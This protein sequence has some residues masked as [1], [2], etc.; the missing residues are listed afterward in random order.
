M[1][2]IITFED[3]VRRAREKH[4][5]K[6]LYDEKS[7]TGM[8]HTVS[9]YCKSCGVWFTQK[10]YSHVDGHGHRDCSF[11][12]S[13]VA[14]RMTKDVFKDRVKEYEKYYVI[15]IEDF[16]GYNK[17]INVRCAVCGKL[18]SNTPKNILRG[19]GHHCPV[20]YKKESWDESSIV[21]LFHQIHGDKYTYPSFAYKN[22]R[23]RITIKCNTCGHKFPVSLNSHKNGHGCKK[24]HHRNLAD[25][26]RKSLEKFI[27]DAKSIHGDLYDYSLVDY[28]G[29]KRY[30]KIICKRCGCTFPQK[31]EVH[32]GNKA[33][34]PNCNHG[35][36]KTDKTSYLY[37]LKTNDET[38]IKV[39]IT[40]NTFKRLERLHRDTPFDFHKVKIYKFTKG[41]CIVDLE[42]DIHNLIAD[43]NAGLRGFDGATEWFWY[44]QDVVDLIDRRVVEILE[45]RLYH[46]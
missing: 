33:G 1:P 16:K 19:N 12:S 14:S 34:C 35:S 8:K 32:L 44:S 43:H 4:H 10:A 29:S 37:I 15:N 11:E 9:I 23:Q 46:T 27:A 42:K 3:F 5:D 31:P 25:T 38:K 24:C 41:T 22:L 20:C 21:E 17:P 7:F 28:N 13:T 45:K 39:G 30:V 18:F 26:Q 40:N 36:I 2:K 6:Y